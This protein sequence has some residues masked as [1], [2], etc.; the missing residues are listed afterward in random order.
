MWLVWVKRVA[1]ARL[2]SRSV[3]YI[4]VGQTNGGNVNVV[5]ALPLLGVT[6]ENAS[7]YCVRLSKVM[8]HLDSNEWLHDPSLEAHERLYDHLFGYVWPDTAPRRRHAMRG[9]LVLQ[10]LQVER[11][12]P[13]YRFMGA[14][15]VG[16]IVELGPRRAIYQWRDNEVP[17]LRQYVGHLLV[18]YVRPAGYCGMDYRLSHRPFA[19][20]MMEGMVV[21]RMGGGVA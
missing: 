7:E 1:Q 13:V 3:T 15:R 14:F 12:M 8:P 20:S 4:G 10:F 17:Q 16:E 19:K 9:H 6:P 11:G 21:E 5:R 2:A 18:R